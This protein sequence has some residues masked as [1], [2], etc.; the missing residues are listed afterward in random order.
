MFLLL[1]CIVL[2]GGE[3]RGMSINLGSFSVRVFN[4][5]LLKGHEKYFVDDY[6]MMV[7]NV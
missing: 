5:L 1:I 4:V 2:H 6:K 7:H 3:M